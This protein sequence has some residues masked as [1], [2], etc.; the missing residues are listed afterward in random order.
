VSLVALPQPDP[1]AAVEP[2]AGFDDLPA[3]MSPRVLADLLDVAPKSL[4]R[5]RDADSGPAYL[6]LPGSALIRYTRDAV[7]AWLLSGRVEA[8]S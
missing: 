1:D 5:W 7:V 2:P 6:K 4:E 8:K 3:V